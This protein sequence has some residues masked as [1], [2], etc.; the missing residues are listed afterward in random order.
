[1]P[2]GNDTTYGTHRWWY[3]EQTWAGTWAGTGTISA[4]DQNS[5][6][7]LWMSVDDLLPPVSLR[8]KIVKQP[9]NYGIEEDE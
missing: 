3:D 2:R 5:P 6:Q 7:N 9:Q 1:M 8:G 4:T